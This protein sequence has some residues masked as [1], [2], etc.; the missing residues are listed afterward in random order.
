MRRYTQ[1]HSTRGLHRTLVQDDEWTRIRVQNRVGTSFDKR[2]IFLSFIQWEIKQ[3]SEMCIAFF[4]FRHSR[5]KTIYNNNIGAAVSAPSRRR[6]ET[7]RIKKDYCLAS[8]VRQWLFYI[9]LHTHTHIHAYRWQRSRSGKDKFCII[10]LLLL[11]LLLLLFA[12]EFYDKYAI[13]Q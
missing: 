3:H 13:Y 6:S 11:L 7:M 12:S 10:L 8:W 9:T 2:F 4:I 5:L 1:I